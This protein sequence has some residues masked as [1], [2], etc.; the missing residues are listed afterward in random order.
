[1][2][3]V[4]AGNLGESKVTAGLSYGGDTLNTAVYYARLGG[5][6]DFLTALGD[7][8]LSDW[9]L[10]CWRSEKVG[11]DFVAQHSGAT[12]G[13]YL[14][15]LDE[16]GERSFMYWRDQSA[17]RHLLQDA[18]QIAKLLNKAVN[19]AQLLYLSGITLA[20]MSVAAHQALFEFAASFR[21]KG[22]LIAFDSNHR[23]ALWRDAKMAAAVYKQMYGNC[24]IA[25][26]LSLI[27]I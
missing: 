21:E 6:V 10:E 4:G 24:D 1:M 13:L 15:Q 2:L 22:G 9:M 5:T 23:P 11:C 14:I 17:A 25:L 26:A 7:D 27:H 18:E 19:E 3:E 16:Q 8:P 20:L 12:P